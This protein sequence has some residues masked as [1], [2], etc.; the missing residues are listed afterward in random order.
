M[1]CFFQAIEEVGAAVL[2]EST[3]GPVGRVESRDVVRAVEAHAAHADGES[4]AAGPLAAHRT[5]TA[6]NVGFDSVGGVADGPA[7]AASRSAHKHS[8]L[9]V[10]MP[11]MHLRS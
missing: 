11:I 5:V 6:M 3:F 8:P 7:Q 1:I 10:A 2:A 4:R 9:L